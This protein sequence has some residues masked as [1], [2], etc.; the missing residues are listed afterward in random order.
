[1]TKNELLF[2]CLD[3]PQCFKDSFI[4]TLV[5]SGAFSVLNFLD[6]FIF[7]NTF[8]DSVNSSVEFFVSVFLPLFF[9]FFTMTF[10]LRLSSRTKFLKKEIVKVN[11]SSDPK[12][13]Q[14]KWN[15]QS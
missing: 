4:R 10:I 12:A 9:I 15:K 11:G 3:A 5:F 13:L 1:M 7:G 6:K 8:A 14:E 2:Y